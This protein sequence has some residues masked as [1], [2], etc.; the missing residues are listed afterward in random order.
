MCREVQNV[1]TCTTVTKGIDLL[2]L[3]DEIVTVTVLHIF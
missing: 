2:F 1:I 3:F